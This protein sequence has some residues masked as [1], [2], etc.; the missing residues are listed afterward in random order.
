LRKLHFARTFCLTDG[1]I[2]AC[3]CRCDVAQHWNDQLP[4]PTRRF[5]NKQVA[6]LTTFQ[7]QPSPAEN[8]FLLQIG[9][10]LVVTM[11]FKIDRSFWRPGD[12]ITPRTWRPQRRRG[13]E[14]TGRKG[15]NW[16]RMAIKT[17]HRAYKFCS[18]GKPS[19]FILAKDWKHL[20]SPEQRFNA[21]F[22]LYFCSHST[23]YPALSILQLLVPTLQSVSLFS[24]SFVSNICCR[25]SRI[26]SNWLL[27]FE[28]VRT[29]FPL[30]IAV[31]SFN[32][33][34]TSEISAS[35]IVCPCLSLLYL[36]CSI[37]TMLA[38]R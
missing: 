28:W 9:H 29:K 18:M 14:T 25:S 8:Y 30:R 11:D 35:K 38:P 16:R 4:P 23:I 24:C 3:A 20:S 22:F 27:G 5:Q 21:T 34:I 13:W 26:F 15:R 10:S 6:I 2:D 17:H 19:D 32:R 31:S 33:I 12:R 1:R 37:L 36:I 7:S